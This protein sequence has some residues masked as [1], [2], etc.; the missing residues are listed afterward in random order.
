MKEK[1][2]NTENRKG[3]EEGDEDDKGGS[4]K[5]YDGER[6]ARENRKGGEEEDEDDGKKTG[7]YYDGEKKEKGKESGR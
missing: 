7:K 6:E 5:H 1:E 4:K 2:K 3:W